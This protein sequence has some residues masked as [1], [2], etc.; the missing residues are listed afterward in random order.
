[1]TGVGS[2]VVVVADFL[3]RTSSR[4]SDL[5]FWAPG[6]FR[7]ES[8]GERRNHVCRAPRRQTDVIAETGATEVISC[9]PLEG[10]P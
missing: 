5:Q 9:P 2:V 1:M 7:S 4:W 3:L 8:I 10:S 6:V